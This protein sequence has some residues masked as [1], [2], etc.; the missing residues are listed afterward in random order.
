M[1]TKIESLKKVIESY[2]LLCSQNFYLPTDL[3]DP[4]A[5]MVLDHQTMQHYKDSL[6]KYKRLLVEAMQEEAE[7]Q[8][9]QR[10]KMEQVNQQLK[11][12]LGKVQYESYRDWLT[13]NDD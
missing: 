2:T 11:D 5:K 10:I 3:L 6:E 1:S 8:E 12:Y 4:R 13:K 9:K 7:E